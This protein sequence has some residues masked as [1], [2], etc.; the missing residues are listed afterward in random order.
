MGA[1]KMKDG[2]EMRGM[3]TT[4]PEIINPYFLAFFKS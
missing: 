2:T 4:Y 1:I 3:W